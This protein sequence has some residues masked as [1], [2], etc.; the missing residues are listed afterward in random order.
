ML[1]PAVIGINIICH[2]FTAA[3]YNDKMPIVRTQHRDLFRFL[4][5]SLL[6]QLLCMLFLHAQGYLPLS[7]GPGYQIALAA[8]N[9]L[10]GGGLH[11]PHYDEFDAQLLKQSEQFQVFIWQDVYSIGGDERLYIKHC[12]LFIF[13]LVPFL[14]FFGSSGPT[15]LAILTLQSLY[16]GMYIFLKNLLGKTPSSLSSMT[17]VFGS[18]LILYGYSMSYDLLAATCILLGCALHE[19]KPFIAGML[20]GFTLFIRP[21]NALYLPFFLYLLH[22]KGRTSCFFGYGIGLGLF[23]LYNRIIWGGFLRTAHTS[24]LAY[25]NGERVMNNAPSEFSFDILF[26]DWFE[27]LLVLPNGFLITLIPAGILLFLPYLWR[28]M[29]DAH[30]KV[31]CIL[32]GTVFVQCLIIFSYAGWSVSV[33]GNRYLLPCYALL[34]CA[35]CLAVENYRDAHK[36]IKH[37]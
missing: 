1:P 16:A 12:H 22:R 8:Q 6:A 28:Y 3:C 11:L 36:T 10:Q 4:L 15:V 26:S 18:T 34:L 35:A 25:K 24:M 33:F 9:I 14:F 31:L 19:R 29:K 37:I 20:F 23:F 32:L 21:T 13:L 27:K 2:C 30:K 17:I 7:P 5:W